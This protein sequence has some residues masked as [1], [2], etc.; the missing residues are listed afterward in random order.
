MRLVVVDGLLRV[1]LFVMTKR[2]RFVRAAN[3]QQVSAT[4]A[5]RQ[6]D[7]TVQ[8]WHVEIRGTVVVGRVISARDYL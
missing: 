4:E 2:A 3:T 8:T 7:Q 5:G 6:G 1:F